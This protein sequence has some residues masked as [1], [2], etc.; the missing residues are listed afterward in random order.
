MGWLATPYDGQIRG[1]LKLSPIGDQ[2]YSFSSN[3]PNS[4]TKI[5]YQ[6]II[7]I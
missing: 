1:D 4:F 2:D 6:N 3:G 7:Y 5:K